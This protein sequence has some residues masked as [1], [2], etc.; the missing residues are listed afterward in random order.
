MPPQNTVPPQAPPPIAPDPIAKDLTEPGERTIDIVRRH[1]IG[2]IFIYIEALAGV[3]ALAAL[4]IFV[5]PDSFKNMSASGSRLLIAGVIFAVAIL[6]FVLFVATYVYR[7]SRVIITDKSLVQVLQKSLF[8][9]DVSRLSF[10][11]VEDVTAQQHGI[12]ATV[13][14]FGTLEVQT[15]GEMDNFLFPTCPDPN[16]FAHEILEARQAY[17]RSVEEIN[18]RRMNGNPIR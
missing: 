1:P 2:L 15:A 13:F 4:L 7:Q 14:N 17:A 8:F 5:A 11:N 16:K 18:E 6:T 10:S 3:L 9:R 12:L